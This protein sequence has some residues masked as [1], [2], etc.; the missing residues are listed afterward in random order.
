VTPPAI[1][2]WGRGDW[3]LAAARLEGAVLRALSRGREGRGVTVNS[4]R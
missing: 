3:D 2:A 1:E 4:Q